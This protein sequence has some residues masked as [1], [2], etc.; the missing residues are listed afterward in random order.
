FAGVAVHQ[1][2]DEAALI[3]IILRAFESVRASCEIQGGTDGAD[4]AQRR[5]GRIR[6]LSRYFGDEIS[7]HRVAGE[8]DLLE[9][10]VSRKLLET[11]AMAAAHT[12]VVKGGSEGFGPAAISLIQA[13]YVKAATRRLLGDAAHVVR[14]AGTFEAVH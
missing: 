10:V 2:G 6:K 4:A 1:A 13:H 12:G 14:F 5:R 8:E 7:A 11:G 3:E 9:A